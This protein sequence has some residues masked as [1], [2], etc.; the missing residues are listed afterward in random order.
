MINEQLPIL[1]IDQFRH[2][3]E[4]VDI[5]ANKLSAHL[6]QHHFIHTPHKHDFYLTVLFTKGKGIHEVD[7][8]SYD[9]K[10][11]S[12]FL[13]KPGQTHN[14]KLSKDIDGYVFFHSSGFYDLHFNSHKLNDYP[15]FS[16][17]QNTPVLHIRKK[18]LKMIEGLIGSVLNE[19]KSEKLFW[20]QKML[21]LIAEI[22]VEVSRLYVPYELS[23]GSQIY[24]AKFG[25]FQKLVDEKYKH[26][27]SPKEY[28]A[29]LNITERHLNRICKTCMNKT[30]TNVITD[31]VVLE[32]KRLLVNTPYTISEIAAG[33]GYFDSS[34]FTRL[35]KMKCRET[36]AVFRKR[37]KFGN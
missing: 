5:Y 1:K 10:P 35:F 28:A 4:N 8:I 36:P 6:K 7:F 3:P 12:I 37:T 14:W 18:K 16:S 21:L 30:S 2:D 29:F 25:E 24:L 22:Y 13:L 17:F 33:L 9:V 19:Y 32:A 34:Y 27:K 26:L 15:F 11:G 31:R 23:S 20:E